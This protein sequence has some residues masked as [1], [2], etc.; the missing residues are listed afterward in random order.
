[1]MLCVC[2]CVCVSECLRES[3]TENVLVCVCVDSDL[4]TNHY[5]TPKMDVPVPWKSKSWTRHVAS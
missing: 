2:V 5:P 4:F 1:M 3:E